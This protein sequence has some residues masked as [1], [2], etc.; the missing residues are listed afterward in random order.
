MH[1]Y[2][3]DFSL[4][5][6]LAFLSRQHP[7]YEEEQAPEWLLDVPEPSSAEEWEMLSF[8]RFIDIDQPEAF[9]NMLQVRSTHS[10]VVKRRRGCTHAMHSPRRLTNTP[11]NPYNAGAEH[12][13]FSMPREAL[14]G[15]GKGGEGMN[16]GESSELINVMRWVLGATRVHPWRLYSAPIAPMDDTI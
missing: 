5:H 2:F 13:G 11:S 3:R 7:D 1:T 10:G 9:A 8:Y 4:A 12:V 14:F 6:S 15:G 16:G